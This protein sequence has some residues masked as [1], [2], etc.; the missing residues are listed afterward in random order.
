VLAEINIVTHTLG[1][2]AMIELLMLIIL[3]AGSALISASEVAFFSL[4]PADIKDIENQKGKKSHLII[5]LLDNPERLLANILILNN[6]INISIIILSTYII[7][8]VINFSYNPLL[9][10]LF[11]VII[12]TGLILLIGEIIPKVFATNHY[13][14]VAFIMAYP[15]FVISKLLFPLTYILIGSTSFVQKKLSSKKLNLSVNDLS[16]ALEITS[17]SLSEEKKLLRGIVKF[18]NIDV[19][20]V[21]QPR[22]DI[23]AVEYNTTIKKLLSII[24]ESAYSRIPV[25]KDTLDNIKGVLYTKDLLPYLHETKSFKWQSL[26]KQAFFV[27]ETKKIDDLLAEFQ[28]NKIHLAVV[29]DEYGGTSGLITMEDILE[30]VI[31][32]IS[33]ESDV[34][35]ESLYKKISNNIYLFEAK[36]LLNDFYKITG[37]DDTA[38]DDVKGEYETLA[39]L[40]LELKGEIPMKNDRIEYRN[41]S[42]VIESVD[43]RRIKQVKVIVK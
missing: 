4:K 39:G 18:G 17:A 20:E 7:H 12:I 36:I 21:M 13:L 8:G 37:T 30:E 9:G 16:D 33:D 28:K 3:L 11:Q 41:F 42:F 38:F 34:D 35:E 1:L 31:G 10:F 22:M 32:E 19:S 27:P 40:L 14:K 15:L 6:F 23:V 24:V 2:E 5:K 26:I 29:I 25:Y 43:K